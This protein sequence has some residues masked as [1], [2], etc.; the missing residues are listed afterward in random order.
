MKPCHFG[1]GVTGGELRSH[2][3]LLAGLQAV[4]Q[5]FE[6]DEVLVAPTF[7]RMEPLGQIVV[8][9]FRRHVHILVLR[10]AYCVSEPDCGQ[11][12]LIADAEALGTCSRHFFL[13]GW[14][15]PSITLF[16]SMIYAQRTG[17]HSACETA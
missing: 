13:L 15:L 6:A 5:C 3:V 14:A 9:T 4:V 10:G 12:R 11:N 7:V 1:L 17:C 16:F 8:S 2:K